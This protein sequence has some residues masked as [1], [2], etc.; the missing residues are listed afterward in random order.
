[1][2]FDFTEVNVIPGIDNAYWHDGSEAL[3]ES[4]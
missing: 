3:I 2:A 4:V 1:M